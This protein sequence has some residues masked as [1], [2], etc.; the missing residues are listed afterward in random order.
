M[1]FVDADD[2]KKRILAIRDAIPRTVP[3][4]PYEFGPQPY[5][6]GDYMRGGLRKALRCLEE[7]PTVIPRGTWIDFASLIEKQFCRHDYKCSVC[8]ASPDYFVGGLG[9]WWCSDAPKYCPYCGAKN[10]EDT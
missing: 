9:D 8:G 1:R 2:V 10:K 7:S 3:P 5:I 4:A 6:A